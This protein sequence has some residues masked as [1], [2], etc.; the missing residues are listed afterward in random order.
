[1][2]LARQVI[3]IPFAGGVDEKSD[4]KRVAPP[5]LLVAEN[6]D[7]STLQ[8]LRKRPQMSEL[9]DWAPP[10]GVTK[11]MAKTESGILLGDG[12]RAYLSS[13][14]GS[15]PVDVGHCPDVVAESVRLVPWTYDPEVAFAASKEAARP[16]DAS[17]SCNSRLGRRVLRMGYSY[18]FFDTATDNLL[19][20]RVN[21]DAPSGYSRIVPTP[22]GFLE[23]CAGKLSEENLGFYLQFRSIIPP[24][25][26]AGATFGDLSNVYTDDYCEHVTTSS[27]VAAFDVAVADSETATDAFVISFYNNR[28]DTCF[29]RVDKIPLGT[30]EASNIW[31]SDP[32]SNVH[33][34]SGV[35]IAAYGSGA[36]FTF[37]NSGALSLVGVSDSGVVLGSATRSV[38]F[39]DGRAAILATTLNGQ[40][41]AFVFYD[42][43]S[44]P[45]WSVNRLEFRNFAYHS[46]S[47]VAPNKELCGKPFEFGG[48]QIVPLYHGSLA[49]ASKA[50]QTVFLKG[51]ESS[52]TDAPLDSDW[53]ILARLGYGTA[54]RLG[55]DGYEWPNYLIESHGGEFV[56]VDHGAPRINGS[57]FDAPIGACLVRCATRNL[58]G[59]LTASGGT[60]VDSGVLRHFDGRAV[61]EHGFLLA[62]D[63]IVFS[64]TS[65]GDYVYNYQFVFAWKDASGRT[66][67]SAMAPETPSGTNTYQRKRTSV[68]ATG[69]A[70]TL[71]VRS[72][73]MSE[74]NIARTVGGGD[75]SAIE[76]VVE[77]YRT[78]NG[79]SVYH[80][81]GSAVPF[82]AFSDSTHDDYL[83]FAPQL[84][85]TGNVLDCDAAPPPRCMVEHQ[86]R[87]WIVSNG[88]PDTLSY[89]RAIIASQEGAEG[90][91]VEFSAAFT[92]KASARGGDINALGSLD[93][94]LIVFE[95]NRIYYLVGNGPDD[96]GSGG[97]FA[98]YPLPFDVGALEGSAVGSTPLGL[99]FQSDK[100]IYLLDRSLQLQYIGKDI[101]ATAARGLV[102]S[103]VSVPGKPQIQLAIP[104]IGSI[105]CYDYLVG[106]WSEWPLNVPESAA[107][108]LLLASGSD[109]YV[110]DASGALYKETEW[111]GASAS[112]EVVS[113]KASTGWIHLGGVGGYQRLRRIIVTGEYKSAHTLNWELY[114]DY[115]DAT[116]AQS[117]LLSLTAATARGG[118]Q[119]RIDV[120]RQKCEA[121]RLVIW[122]SA[123]TAG[124]GCRLSGIA[125]EIGVKRG[126][127]KLPGGQ[128]GG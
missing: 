26:G 72:R 78:T 116:P 86:K 110:L 76:P 39:D 115:N 64:G 36:V 66:H 16:Y 40:C 120:V 56:F 45:E 114:T 44:N 46:S 82:V 18:Y 69:S 35:A 31:Y 52:A 112:G 103:I 6:C 50:Q 38:A 33:G 92:E 60:H 63:N 48:M 121:V 47:C 93:E 117:G 68:I 22:T 57:Y 111:S 80:L 102:T 61:F 43:Y 27:K 21:E 126:L 37:S 123:A 59:G 128:I 113:M 107:P 79:G 29:V 74:K 119:A 53:A 77:V 67:R 41:R 15:T 28:T 12:R 95:R 101:E 3:D 11:L 32:V 100:G 62:P 42:A 4:P 81:V 9:L 91:P 17:F 104:S 71:T 8:Q 106:Q 109:V 89:S 7:F 2:V 94:K 30:G 34:I 23:V 5:K 125:L 85:T 88:A 124:E 19:E 99:V 90:V 73:G 24:L 20:V 51:I 83:Q 96:T 25:S 1:M 70:L 65:T 54:G 87:I 127:T 105:L 49:G 58:L 75:A 97:S 13:P 118:L 84:Y 98:S 14:I 122:D 55:Y 108:S 10:T